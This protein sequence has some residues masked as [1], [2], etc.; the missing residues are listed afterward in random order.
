[1][2]QTSRNSE[3]DKSRKFKS[4][5]GIVRGICVTIAIV[6]MIFTGIAFAILIRI[7]RVKKFLAK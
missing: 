4:A 2:K 6:F 7:P 3:Q 1:M 5:Q